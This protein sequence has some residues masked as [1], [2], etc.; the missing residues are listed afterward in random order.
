MIE[1]SHRQRTPIKWCCWWHSCARAH[2]L[3][4]NSFY[5]LTLLSFAIAFTFSTG[6][7]TFYFSLD[8]VYFLATDI[9]AETKIHTQR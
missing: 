2:T 6:G 4:L 5:N 3:F 9:R 7:V 1:S 8:L